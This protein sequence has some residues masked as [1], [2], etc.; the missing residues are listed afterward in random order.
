MT[1]QDR[2]ILAVIGSFGTAMHRAG[3]ALGSQQPSLDTR[4]QLESALH[5]MAAQGAAL[6]DSSDD[7]ER[8]IEAFVA[9]EATNV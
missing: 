7:V 6:F 2:Q 4:R 9:S 3:F 8:A 5:L 1:E